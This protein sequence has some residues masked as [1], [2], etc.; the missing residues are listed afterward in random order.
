MRNVLLLCFLLVCS[1]ALATN[2]FVNN[3][4]GDNGNNGLAEGT[5]FKNFSPIAGVNFLQAGDV[6]TISNDA[7]FYGTDADMLIRSAGTID[8]PIIIQGDDT[9][10]LVTLDGSVPTSDIAGWTG[11]TSVGSNVWQSNVPVGFRAGGVIVNGTSTLAYENS[12]YATA[13]SYEK[14]RFSLTNEF[15]MRVRMENDSDPNAS[16]IRFNKYPVGDTFR[17][18][19][20]TDDDG[21]GSYITF[22]NIYIK[23]S[24][25]MGFSSSGK[26]VKFENCRADFN[27]REAFY[28]IS[29]NLASPASYNTLTD[30]QAWWNNTLYAGATGQAITTEAPYTTIIRPIVKYNWMAGVDWLDYSATTN[31][32][33][34]KLI[35][36]EIKY[37]SRRSLQNT[38]NTGFD[39]QVYIDGGNN[40]LI[41]DN[42]IYGNNDASITGTFAAASQNG[43]SNI[44][45]GSEHPD[46][47]IVHDIWVINNEVRRQTLAAI[48]TGNICYAGIDCASYPTA[49][50]NIYGIYLAGNFFSAGINFT[51]SFAN[52]SITNPRTLWAHN[53]IFVNFSTAEPVIT[54]PTNYIGNF[55]LFKNNDANT[56][57]KIGASSYSLASIRNITQQ[58][59]N[60]VN[61]D[62]L[63]V[64][65]GGNICLQQTA[66]GDAS[67]SPAVNA[68]NSAFSFGRY[69]YSVLGY[70]RKDGVADTGALDIGFHVGSTFDCLYGLGEENCPSSIIN[71]SILK[72]YS[73]GN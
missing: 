60:S 44:S 12:A 9:I 34:G 8:N 22:K 55:N 51:T 36:G 61:S 5:A 28:I 65:C 30:V 48:S 58:E 7:T 71:N 45:I 31:A 53:N 68:G 23:G 70:T 2:Y 4:T 29:N 10:N 35:A 11:W 16:V 3:A 39:P 37:N 73:N 19:V 18:L 15:T 69:K 13:A 54:L 52:L 43:I 49:P 14:G 46:V 21:V 25:Q 20:R 33:Y 27:G 47:K 32:S 6:V 56:L 42:T 26:H 50:S 67:N 63:T 1:P 41:V 66:A 57:I 38:D 17:G 64:V 40:I 59:K 62:P 24:R 72:N